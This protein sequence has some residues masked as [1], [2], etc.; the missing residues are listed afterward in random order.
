ML[1]LARLPLLVLV[2]IFASGCITA[3]TTIK[4]Q[5]DGSGTIEQSM[6]MKAAM[7]EQLAAMSAGMGGGAAK[8]AAAG[9]CTPF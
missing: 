2:C 7:A 4:L 6:A 1:K 9:D 5:P 8:P 3:I